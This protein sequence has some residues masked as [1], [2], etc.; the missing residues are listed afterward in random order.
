MVSLDEATESAR[1]HLV[2]ALD[3]SNLDEAVEL[4]GRLR[5]WFSVVKVGLELFSADGPLAVDTL[6]DDGF[7]VF[8]DLKLHDIPTTVGR[9]ARRIGSLGVS[10][11]TVHAAG[12]A[13]M[14]RAAVE[15][16][17]EGWAGAVANGHP[18]PEA[19]SAGILAV[20]VLTSDA[21]IGAE[22]V[23][24]RASLAAVCGC[25]GVVCAASDLPAI[26]SRA[27][28]LLTAVPG[29]RLAGSSQDDQAR[30]AR[31]YLAIREGADLLVIGRTV[32]ASPSPEDAAAQLT[33]EVMSALDPDAATS[34]L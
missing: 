25:L 13:E 34:E 3:V 16:F 33:A 17:E 18:A 11:A 24:T 27:P 20:T 30:A 9:A 22:L 4:A 29:I 5:P 10:Y 23:A 1:E 28:G 21:A 8:L 6:L 15:G 14:L 32:T 31:P 7:G 26:A 2:L 12:G 19:G